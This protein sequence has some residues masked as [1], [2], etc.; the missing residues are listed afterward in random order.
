MRLFKKTNKNHC[1]SFVFI[2]G[3]DV[4]ATK[5]PETNFV[6]GVSLLYDVQF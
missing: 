6:S 5:T 1:N 4:F 2:M 3:C